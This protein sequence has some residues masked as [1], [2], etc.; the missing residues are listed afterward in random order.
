MSGPGQPAGDD[1]AS[2]LKIREGRLGEGERRSVSDV[3]GPWMLGRK[4]TCICPFWQMKQSIGRTQDCKEFFCSL[5]TKW[6]VSFGVSDWLSCKRTWND[7]PKKYKYW[8]KASDEIWDGQME[9][10]TSEFVATKKPERES[11]CFPHRNVLRRS[12]KSPFTPSIFF[13]VM[14]DVHRHIRRYFRRPARPLCISNT[15]SS[16][17]S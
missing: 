11:C 10:N 13:K 17:L 7:H 16:N 14:L 8:I 4:S 15:K 12:Y 9:T 2:G 6:P 5:Q 1:D 3:C